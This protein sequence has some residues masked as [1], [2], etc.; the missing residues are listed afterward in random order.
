MASS[1]SSP[2]AS[3]VEKTN[4]AKLS[5][6]L[7]D[8]G[9]MVLRKIFVRYIPPANLQAKLDENYD[10]LN[11]LL[12]ERVL[13]EPQWRLLFPP[14]GATPDS[15]TF[16]ISLLFLLLTSIC[17]LSPPRSGW[18]NKPSARDSSVAAN[19]ARIKFFRNK[20]YS[21]VTTT[22]KKK[23]TFS[24]LWEEISAVLVAM[25]LH[26]EEIKRLEI[27]HCG[28][29]DFLNVLF[30]WAESEKDIKSQL[31]DLHQ[32]V[33]KTRQ[34]VAEVRK[35]QLKDQKTIQDVKKIVEDVRNLQSVAVTPET[36]D[37]KRQT[38]LGDRGT[39]RD[40]R[41]DTKL[42]EEVEVQREKNRENEILKKLAKIDPLKTVRNH[43]D[44]YVDGTRLSFF[45]A[46]DS[47]LNDS[48][49]PNRVMV[50]SGSAGMGKSVISAVICEKMQDAGRL[51]GSHFCQHDR[52]RHR[53]P[54][55]MLQS[56]ASQ[57]CDILPEYKKALVEKLSRNLGVEIN[58]MEVKDLFEVLFEEPL[59]SLN[60]SSLAYL[61]VIDGLD[62]SEFQG[63]NELLDV[64]AN[65]FQGLPL[66]IR[67]LVTTRP[68]IN[69]A[70]NLKSM[71]PLLLDPNA[72]DNVKDIYLC[73]DKQIS[74][75][76]QSEHQEI[77]LRALVQKSEGV[78]LYAHYL[79]DF[80][81]KEK[82]VLT[83]EL[84]DSILPSGISSVYCSYFKRL[85]TE[86][87]VMEDLFFTFLSVV[88][89]SGE[90]LPL[91]FVSKL[92]LPGKS[93]SAVHR[94]VKAAISCVSALLP[95]EDGCIHFFHKSVK[96]WLIDKSNYGQHHFS[97]DE[98]EG[99]EVLSK[100]CTDELNELKRKGVD[101]AQ[102]S[103]ITKYALRHGVQHM[104]LEDARECSLED[105]V[106]KFVLDIE[107]VYAKLCVN[108]TAAF[109]DIVCVQ[110]QAGIE[111]VQRPLNTLLV[112]LRKHIATLEKLPHTVFQI[113]LNEGGPELS[114]QAL[115]LL[116]TRYSE[117]AYVEYLH[118]ENM[119]R[120]IQAEFR[121]SGAVACFD[122]SPQLDYMV[123][124]CIDNT[125]QL[126]SLHTGKQLWKRD[127]EV[128][129]DYYCSFDPVYE[130]DVY[131]PYRTTK[132]FDMYFGWEQEDPLISL[133]LLYRSV[134]FH[135]TQDLV[136]PGIL[137]H[138][139]SFDG[140]LR[141]LFLSSSCCFSVCS[142]SADKMLTDCTSD[143][144]SIIMWSLTDGS[145]INR[146]TW[147]DDIVSF[148]LSRDGG[149][150][151]V[152]DFRGS[153]GLCDVMDDYRTL[154]QTTISGVCGMIK[155]SSDCQC[156]YCFNSAWCELFRL[157]V[158]VGDDG[159]LSLDIS[160]NE[161][162]YHPWEFES[163][164]EPGFLLGDPFYLLPKEDGA[165]LWSSGLAFVLNK[166]SVLRVSSVDGSIIEMLQLDELTKDSA[167]DAEAIVM[168]VV[169]SLNGDRLF[170]IT[171]QKRELMVWDIS[172]GM[173]K[174]G[175]VLP[176]GVH[177]NANLVAVREG[178][179]LQ[180][181]NHTLELWDF[182][183]R[184]CIRS[185]NALE[186]IRRVISISEDQVAC[187]VEK[188]TSVLGTDGTEVKKQ[189]IIVDT[190]REAFVS[191][192]TIHGDFVAC[193]SKC[194]VIT[195]DL[196][197]LQM[198]CGADV[199][200]KIAVPFNPDGFYPVSSFS[201]TEQ[202]CILADFNALYVLD[203]ALGQ[204]LCTLQPRIHVGF[205]PE[206]DN[207]KFVSDEE[208]VACFRFG[209]FPSYFLQLFNVKSGDLL[210]EIAL[211]GCVYSLAA[212]P[213]ERLVA[214]GFMGSKV[215]FRVLQVKLPGD[216]H[217]RRSKRSG[218]PDKNQSYN[219]MTS[220][221]PT[222]RF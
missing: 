52:A 144:K 220:T 33:A 114:S 42:E 135:P 69:I 138:A 22:G 113:F 119:Q 85:E 143:A 160:H 68:E 133:K 221:E 166:Q 208:C 34:T 57:L 11:D 13:S 139:Y 74:H 90:P 178:L 181:S 59:A 128:A 30:Q 82:P 145:E 25:G 36:I 108:V 14:G 6:L 21:H 8:G 122:V 5:R 7:I 76:L 186:G 102:F 112:L 183:L 106:T 117:M 201:P 149:L 121:C 169:F 48:S 153:I 78:M 212:S 95:V 3:S 54:K 198:Q 179:L 150:L 209:D 51:A 156:L 214:I 162:S 39:V 126:W 86:L 210:S 10:I 115:N 2:L 123:C 103:D 190:A 216:Q 43:A 79:A 124:E 152:S 75:L 206:I 200:W 61:M 171:D 97:V 19:L 18:H 148:S 193:N 185:W 24:A 151:A 65:Y 71:H 101:G 218:F 116:G 154:A 27:E 70:E 20:V 172:S 141:P 203:V 176:W 109:E 180:T 217:S 94:K 140:E 111:K 55:V 125:I 207:F 83:P 46:V 17:G 29:E 77:V 92:L 187:I 175:K 105:V 26:R 89:A 195:T 28:E 44:R 31:R 40:N 41:V 137:S 219:T 130:D 62:E 64:I 9:T 118:K 129:K 47:W 168:N 35:T 53:N 60:D 73:F 96:D 173:L 110:K 192:I 58:N 184:E 191:T 16:D 196:W 205:L 188:R 211:E 136:L 215:N 80:I 66:W 56:L 67:F 142:I 161:V 100:L 38:Q 49:S 81:K 120:H 45:S 202:Y 159:G 127:V 15:N 12:L 189:V 146:F 157:D 199:F 213:G 132:S 72:Q 134:V 174:P 147:N 87:N 107:L 63:R 197:E 1:S 88:A 50:I 98:K 222:E 99:H 167:G 194:H 131:E 104:L 23:A 163:A 155:F 4:G 93:T 204:T 91:G 177:R 170:I 32:D 84:L 158:N 182:E 164:S 37:E 165:H